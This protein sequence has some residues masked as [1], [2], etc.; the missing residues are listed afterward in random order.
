MARVEGTDLFYYSTVLEPEARVNYLFI[1]DYEEITDR[2]NAR[3]TT[4]GIYGS[5]MEFTESD[6]DPMPMSWVAM[7]RWRPRRD[8]E[9]LIADVHCWIV[10][11]QTVLAPYFAV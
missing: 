9:R 2:R 1:R 11:N 10:D 5:D 8:L 7:P 6:D 3:S 4:T